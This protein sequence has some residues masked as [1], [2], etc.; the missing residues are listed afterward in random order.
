MTERQEKLLNAIINEFVD[1]AEAVGSVHL[2]KK[3]KFEISS[4]TIRNEMAELVFRGYLYKRHSSA[5][6]I[7]TTKG[8]RF[9]V[10]NVN[11]KLNYIDAS[12]DAIGT[13][14][15]DK[16]LSRLVKVKNEKSN[17]I[18]QSLNYLSMIAENP[19]V[20]LIGNDLYYAGLSK[21]PDIPDFQ[22]GESL[23][24][25]LEILEDYYMLNDV[26]RKSKGEEGVSIVI[27]EE[28]AGDKRFKDYSVIFSRVRFKREGEVGF[29]AV[30]GPNR[31]DYEKVITGVKYIT[32]TIR[33]LVNN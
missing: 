18:R 14:Q 26:F 5:G 19:A 10:D 9:F 17:L 7:P 16:M 30:I 3:Y 21:I 28:E 25:I 33:F 2:L 29:I 11:K 20:A 27:G 23:H 31:M 6:R 12:A 15:K 4:A 32:D 22:E 8:W 13:T 1:S 24:R